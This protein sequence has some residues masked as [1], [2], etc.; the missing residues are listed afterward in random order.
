MTSEKAIKIIEQEIACVE[1]DCNIERSCGDCELALPSKEPIIE[2]YQLAIKAFDTLN[3]ILEYMNDGSVTW[4]DITDDII[5]QILI[6]NGWKE[7]GEK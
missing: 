2:A 6:E 7:E 5:N 4:R 1:K 3:E